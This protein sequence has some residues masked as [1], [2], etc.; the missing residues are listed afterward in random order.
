MPLRKDDA[1]LISLKKT[2]GVL[3]KKFQS[4]GKKI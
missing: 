1:N 4:E 2:G 3:I